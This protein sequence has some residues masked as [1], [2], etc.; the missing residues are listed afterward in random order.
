MNNIYKQKVPLRKKIVDFFVVIINISY[1]IT[2]IPD[3]LL[4]NSKNVFILINLLII[5][6]LFIKYR[7]GSLKKIDLNLIKLVN[8]PI[9]WV[10]MLIYIVE[11]IKSL[12]LKT[13]YAFATPL[14]LFFVFFSFLYFLLII[15]KDYSA[16]VGNEKALF[17]I[18]NYYIIFSIYNV[19]IVVI[20]FILL[21]MNLLSSHANNINNVFSALSNNVS[22]NENYFFPGFLYV[23]STSAYGSRLSFQSFGVFCGLSFEPHLI[24]YLVTPSLFFLSSRQFKKKFTLVLII[25][26]YLLFLFLTVSAT[27]LIALAI[28]IPIVLIREIYISKGEKKVFLLVGILL[29]F[30]IGVLYFL[31]LAKNIGLYSF[32]ISKWNDGSRQFSLSLL[33]QAI[34]ARTLLGN[35]SFFSISGQF[36]NYKLDIGF[37]SEVLNISFVAFFAYYVFKLI[38]KI[39]K[40]YFYTGLGL[41]YF[42]IHSA[43]IVFLSY[44]NLIL[45]YFLFFVIIYQEFLKRKYIFS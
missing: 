43:K 14:L 22:R 40:Q 29:I 37:I 36:I 24:T 23:L 34:G 13:T 25:S 15:F 4:F 9:L 5:N 20:S 35:D 31:T 38:L 3:L 33:G 26:V 16:Y 10:L 17:E 1:P 6:V 28:I 45:I 32:F 21:K 2:I 42:L 39:K 27:N 30:I 7:G 8:K 18:L 19:L 11:T 41:L 44:S 12:F